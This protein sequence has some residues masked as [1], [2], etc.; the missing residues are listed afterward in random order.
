MSEPL[1][2]VHGNCQA[3][4][5][6][7]V[8]AASGAGTVCILHRVYGFRPSCFGVQPFILS[9]EEAPATAE[10]I[11]GY[12][13]PVVLVEQATP[14]A[15]PLPADYLPG[16]PRIRF[17]HVQLQSWWPQNPDEQ[18]PDRLRRFWN[19]DL[20]SLRRSEAAAGLD[21]AL[22]AYI[23]QS[24]A[25]RPLFWM[26]VHP[27]LGVMRRLYG[28][29]CDGLRQFGD[30]GAENT[31]SSMPEMLDF[32]CE[33]PLRDDVVR[34]LGLSWA[35]DGWYRAWSEAVAAHRRGDDMA[36]CALHE[37]LLEQPDMS[38]HVWGSYGTALLSIG[39]NEDA[40]RAFGAA[41]RAFPH[42]SNYRALWVQTLSPTAI[43]SAEEPLIDMIADIYDPYRNG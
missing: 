22:S 35:Q 43:G 18:T 17:P 31:L 37:Q 7:A 36:S 26:P 16:V 10:R 24:A 33:H 14:L 28:I 25:E 34:G 3:H 19:L 2:L 20:A 29:I 12:G 6:A 41:H 8:L 13:R 23:E 15:P 40:H 38:K 9:M 32:Y 30:Y 21:T 1:I 5:L 27:D 39:R 4:V 11:S 42:N